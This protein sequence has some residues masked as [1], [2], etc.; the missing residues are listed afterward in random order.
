M[1]FA[2]LHYKSFRKKLWMGVT[3]RKYHTTFSYTRRITIF[4]G[5]DWFW[6]AW[7]P[8]AQ[9]NNYFLRKLFYQS[10][11]KSFPV[12]LHTISICYQ[13][14]FKTYA[15]KRSF[16]SHGFG[17]CCP[18]WACMESWNVKIVAGRYSNFRCQKNVVQII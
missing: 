15:K 13:K 10:K 9:P 12:I 5:F 14:Y 3:T 18:I 17:H 6:P 11:G 8:V 1:D 16:L 4:A 2:Q 7:R